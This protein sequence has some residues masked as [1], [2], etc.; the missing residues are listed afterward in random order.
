MKT[1]DNVELISK[2]V[3]EILNNQDYRTVKLVIEKVKMEVEANLLVK[4]R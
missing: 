1:Q 2:K 3:L 4:L